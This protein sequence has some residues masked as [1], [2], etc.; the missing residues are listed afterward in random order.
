MNTYKYQSQDIDY[1]S[2]QNNSNTGYNER[3]LATELYWAQKLK[4]Y[5]LKN[6]DEDDETDFDQE[7]INESEKYAV[8]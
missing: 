4:E 7:E 6:E 3:L 1:L 2:H 8:D 5:S